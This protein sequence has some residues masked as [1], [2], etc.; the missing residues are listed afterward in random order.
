M[1]RL[2]VRVQPGAKRTRFAG[3]Y[4]A[5][6]RLAVV[7]PT[8]DG[9]ANEAVIVALAE[10]LDLKRRLV[11][12]IGGVAWRTKRVEIDDVTDQ[13]LQDRIAAINPR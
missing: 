8:I 12:L 11:R 1:A 3:W 10:L 7:A 9:A 6:P 13:E 4:G 2:H 5:I